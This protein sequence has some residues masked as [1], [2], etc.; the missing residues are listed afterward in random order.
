[1]NDKTTW[2]WDTVQDPID[3]AHWDTQYNWVEEYRV[4]PDGEQ[5]AAIVNLGE[6]EFGVCVNGKL[7]EN[8]FEK[9]WSLNFLPDGRLAV[10]AASDEEWT[11]YIDDTPWLNRF[12]YIW[13]LQWSDDGSHVAAAVQKET[14]YG[15]AVDD[16]IWDNLYENLTCPL[17]DNSGASA[18]VVQ[19]ESL[20]QGDIERFRQG[21]FCA[22]VNGTPLEQSFVN[23]WDLRFDSQGRKITY[24]ARKNR[25]DY[26]VVN[27]TVAWP[28]NFQAAWQPI[29]TD[30]D[31]CVIAPV[32]HQGKWYLYKDGAPFWR[33]GFE[34]LW[35]LTV[36][37]AT[38]RVAAVVA[39][40]FGKWTVCEQEKCWD[41]RVNEMVHDLFYSDNGERLLA[42]VKHNRFWDLAVDGR[43]WGLS[44]D[45]LWQPCVSPDASIITARMLQKGK[46]HLAVN[47]TVLP[48]AYD[49]AFN[50]VIHPDRKKIMCKT[51][52]N[53][54][55]SR[56]VL[57]VDQFV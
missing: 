9:A 46:Y 16:S 26:T 19:K 42:T 41:I 32:R 25:S 30:Q 50:P 51:I 49:M 34:Q 36:S 37:P 4:S 38:S 21:I 43:R 40:A 14:A 5:V 11:V 12:D 54:T 22:A 53:K 56:T 33:S 57:D 10:L 23:V 48:Q 18:A 1:M 39:P 8:R 47:S 44:C 24:I 55:Y 6:M 52:V 17:L 27:G 28:G 31:A 45:K 20:G 2:N 29:F 7:W 13:G 35:K 3:L 15:M